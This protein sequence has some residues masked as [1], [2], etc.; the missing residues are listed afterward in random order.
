MAAARHKSP[1]RRL[2]RRDCWIGQQIRLPQQTA[3][4][5]PSRFRD[6]ALLETNCTQKIRIQGPRTDEG[7]QEDGIME[8]GAVNW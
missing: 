8:G 2:I 4:S 5:I 1:T 7:L 6:R 3:F